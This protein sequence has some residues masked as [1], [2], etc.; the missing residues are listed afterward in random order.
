MMLRSRAFVEENQE[1]KGL[2]ESL[3][4]E[5]PD[6]KRYLRRLAR[7]QANRTQDNEDYNEI[8][9][10]IFSL[11]ERIRYE[12][13]FNEV[14]LYLSRGQG[15]IVGVAMLGEQGARRHVCLYTNARQL[16]ACRVLLKEETA[17]NASEHLQ[18][19]TQIPEWRH[20]L[21]DEKADTRPLRGLVALDQK[22][23]LVIGGCRLGLAI[24]GGDQ[25]RWLSPLATALRCAAY[26][27]GSGLLVAGGEWRPGQPEL[28]Y[29]FRLD[30]RGLTPLPGLFPSAESLNGPMTVRAL[31]WDAQ[32]N[33]WGVT[34]ESGM[35]LRWPYARGARTEHPVSPQRVNVLNCSQYVLACHQGLILTGGQDGVLRAFRPNGELAWL[36]IANGPIRGI[37]SFEPDADQSPTLAVISEREHLWTLDTNGRQQGLLFLPHRHPSALCSG[38]LSE[39]GAIHH[40]LGSLE[41]EVRVVEAVP[42]YANWGC[43][44]YLQR[45]ARQGMEA[46][47]EAIAQ[48]KEAVLEQPALLRQWCELPTLRDEP[49]RA[50]WA[51]RHLLERGERGPVFAA[52]DSVQGD[53]SYGVLQFRSHVFSYLGQALDRLSP[54]EFDR[55]QGLCQNS[56]RDGSLASL[57]LAL[58][59]PFEHL[60]YWEGLWSCIKEK[61]LQ[62]KP[63]TASALVTRLAELNNSGDLVNAKAL[64]QALDWLLGLPPAQRGGVRIGVEEGLLVALF[65]PLRAK[66]LDLLRMLGRLEPRK[67]P[68]SHKALLRTLDCHAMTLFT[69][70]EGLLWDA[71][72]P[73]LG[74]TPPAGPFDPLSFLEGLR[75]KGLGEKMWQWLKDLFAFFFPMDSTNQV[76]PRGPALEGVFS[77]NALGLAEWLQRERQNI[78]RSHYVPKKVKEVLDQAAD[79]LNRYRVPNSLLG[80]IKR[81]WSDAWKR[82]LQRLRDQHLPAAKIDYLFLDHEPETLFVG[83][84]P[85]PWR[86]W[87]RNLGPED[88]QGRVGLRIDKAKGRLQQNRTTEVQAQ[89][90]RCA[91]EGEAG[92]ALELLAWVLPEGGRSLRCEVSWGLEGEGE[93]QRTLEIPLRPRWM[94]YRQRYPRRD[95]LARR[96]FSMASEGGS[97]F[98][99]ILVRTWKAQGVPPL[100]RQE[101]LSLVRDWAAVAGR[102]AELRVSTPESGGRGI[103]V[104]PVETWQERLRREPQGLEVWL[105]EE[106][107]PWDL[108]FLEALDQAPATALLLPQLVLEETTDLNSQ[109]NLLEQLLALHGEAHL[110][111]LQWALKA[112]VQG[113]R[114][115]RLE[116]I[117]MTSP[118]WLAAPQIHGR[119]TLARGERP[120]PAAWQNPLEGYWLVA[121]VDVADRR[122]GLPPD[123]AWPLGALVE[124]AAFRH[125]WRM[126]LLDQWAGIWTPR[127]QVLFDYVDA[128]YPP[129]PLKV[130]LYRWDWE[131]KTWGEGVLRSVRNTL[132]GNGRGE[133][134]PFS[135]A[136]G[137]RLGDWR[138]IQDYVRGAALPAEYFA[139]LEVPAQAQSQLQEQLP[140]WERLLSGENEQVLLRRLREGD[141]VWQEEAETLELE[142]DRVRLVRLSIPHIEGRFRH[143]ALL[144]PGQGLRQQW[145][146]AGEEA[147]RRIGAFLME[148]ARHLDPK[149]PWNAAIPLLLY[150][151]PA[152]LRRWD[153]L[154]QH[155]AVF[156]HDRALNRLMISRRPLAE[157]LREIVQAQIPL[158]EL[159]QRVFATQG[160]VGPGQFFGRQGSLHRLREGLLARKSYVVTGP[161]TIGKSSLLRYLV[162]ADGWGK[163]LGERFFPLFLDLQRHRTV[164]DYAEFLRALLRVAKVSPA[165]ALEAA[166]QRL[167]QALDRYKAADRG[168]LLR[169]EEVVRALN[170]AVSLGLDAIEGQAR[171]RIPLYLLDEADGFYKYDLGFEEPLFTEFRARH[172][173]EEEEA[174]AARFLF[175]AYPQ[176]AAGMA[177]LIRNPNRQSY[178]FLELERLGP[179]ELEEGIDLIRT[180]LR[181]LAVSIT[182]PQARFLAEQT[183]AIPSLLQEACLGLCKALESQIGQGKGYDIRQITLEESARAVQRKYVDDFWAMLK[184][185][186]GVQGEARDALKNTLLGLVLEGRNRFTLEEAKEALRRHAG[187]V[188][189]KEQVRQLLEHLLHTLM[190]TYEDGYYRF[191]GPP[192]RP[193]FP[194]MAKEAYGEDRLEERVIAE[195][196]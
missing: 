51:A 36:F 7:E 99:R 123:A 34:R 160:P 127:S 154:R 183:F 163:A 140:H 54:A 147:P 115:V 66:G 158:S 53:Y 132:F 143:L 192:D 138:R 176:E 184:E 180:G 19:E 90:L 142:G 22:R 139:L 109:W 68:E 78:Q 64:E 191:S 18:L 177:G 107:I 151:L 20:R 124:A 165:P 40:L 110:A 97:V 28:L 125:L 105:L 98:R 148:V 168:D 159:A 111:P 35:V 83:N 86:L 2:L 181:R 114:E 171:P 137:F 185:T 26:D 14:I 129:L 188:W 76:P 179:L 189:E 3:L 153:A 126:G 50:A 13:L 57:L 1:V 75:A 43:R 69:P 48:A 162:G 44:D 37:Q 173:R 122:A 119:R 4:D 136:E 93:R 31:A 27:P 120:E 170:Q 128:I 196:E 135:P 149:P 38:R 157:V 12:R 169:K 118:L 193:Y 65:R 94:E 67:N 108:G 101:V 61:L 106:A 167:E 194:T 144:L 15:G 146:E 29:A 39:Q 103:E 6:A 10:K 95:A 30:A 131:P 96:L 42:Q 47:V 80:P 24:S 145:Q 100:S 92:D 49:L 141:Q 116:Q 102:T 161:R 85:A 89:G 164:P 156:L 174:G 79:R 133:P 5:L 62:A 25:V 121:G 56:V 73:W 134:P 55:L 41:G 70:D 52:L 32:G 152:R 155:Y 104:W 63:F 130:F 23:L 91:D 33:L 117:R 21:A 72:S 166:L 84:E 59:A 175:A 186:E 172:N 71:L 113:V 8:A 45:N 187:L 150:D 87:L 112:S 58:P 46:E 190:L 88:L 77:S 195:M 60:P 178:N 82:E 74:Q 81:H 11:C 182:E 16:Y 17:G 9:G